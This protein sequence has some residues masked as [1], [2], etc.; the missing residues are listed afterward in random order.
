MANCLSTSILKNIICAMEARDLAQILSGRLDLVEAIERK[1]RC[2]AETGNAFVPVRE[3]FASVIQA[4]PRS[5][6]TDRA[7]PCGMR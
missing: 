4:E 2:A 7:I 5:R 3:F 6:T 1:K